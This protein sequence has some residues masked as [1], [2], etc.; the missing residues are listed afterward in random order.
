MVLVMCISCWERHGSPVDT[1]SV[2]RAAEL[3]ATIYRYSGVGLPFHVE[4]DDWNI[5]PPRAFTDPFPPLDDEWDID[6]GNYWDVAQIADHK[7]A[8]R[9]LQTLMLAM[10]A[11]ERASA[12]ALADGFWTLGGRT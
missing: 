8:A 9:K 3:I 2:R 10:P 11:E 7:A 6:D 4:L 5:D 1:P 12:L